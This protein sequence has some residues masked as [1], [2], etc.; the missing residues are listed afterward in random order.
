M[1]LSAVVI[2]CGRVGSV[3]DNGRAGQDPRSH[4]GSYAAAPGIELVAGVDPNDERRAAFETLWQVPAYARV[5][6]MLPRVRPEV[7]SVCTPAGPRPDLIE[8]ALSSGARAI[9]AE[10]PLASSAAAAR[11]VVRRSREAGVPLAVNY[12]RRWDPAHIAFAEAIHRGEAG[13]IQHVAVRYTRGLL[14]YGTHAIDLLRWFVGEPSWLWAHE[15][16]D[17]DETDP[18]PVIAMGFGDGP[19]AALLPIDRDAHDTFEVDLIG[20][21]ARFTLRDRGATVR[22]ERVAVDRDWSEPRV[23]RP[24]PDEF[25]PGLRG[26]MLAAVKNLM[27][28]LLRPEELRCTGED[29][30]AA[31]EIVEAVRESLRSGAAVLRSPRE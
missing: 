8:T 3:Y 9:W 31:L 1:S 7:W 19:I 15:A 2:G 11:T 6:D 17:R 10:K 30:L 5:E 14:N 23:L 26:M 27:A 20:T 25:P 29:G 22:V 4:A 24:A 16:L 28:A 21:D 12:P 13:R 18:S